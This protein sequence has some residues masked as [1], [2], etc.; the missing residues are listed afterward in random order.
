MKLIQSL[1]FGS[2]VGLV[3]R[4]AA[5]L[6][7]H[8]WVA[9]LYYSTSYQQYAFAY[10]KRAGVAELIDGV[11]LDEG[12]T[13]ADLRTYPVFGSPGALKR[14]SEADLELVAKVAR[15]IWAD[16]VGPWLVGRPMPGFRTGMA[17]SWATIQRRC[18]GSTFCSNPGWSS[19]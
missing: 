12:Q 19:Y 13:P 5:R 15:L 4:E 7:W 1:G 18:P 10:A 3:L 11:S 6:K 17:Y 16:A 2:P 8:E 9:R 14:I